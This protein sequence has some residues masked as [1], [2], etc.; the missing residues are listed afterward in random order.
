MQQ[1]AEF[2]IPTLNQINAAERSEGVC[3]TLYNWECYKAGI[4]TQMDLK[5]TI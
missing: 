4:L 1:E 3:L 5:Y 2:A